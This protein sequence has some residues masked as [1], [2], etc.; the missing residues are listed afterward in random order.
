[1]L[2]IFCKYLLIYSLL[3]ITFNYFNPC[4]IKRKFKYASYYLTIF[5]QGIILPY[6]YLN[7][8]ANSKSIQIQETMFLSTISY[9]LV[10]LFINKNQI[11]KNIKFLAHHLLSIILLNFAI[12]NFDLS[13]Y[14][15]IGI[16]FYLEFG[17]L[18]ISI[19]DLFPS[20]I[21]YKLR[22]FFYLWS[23][24][25]I[26]KLLTILI[27]NNYLIL[28]FRLFLIHSFISFFLYFHN[29][30]IAYYLYKKILH[31]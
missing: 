9:F 4:K 3:G 23:R 13:K 10:D 18:W 22:F 29:C 8:D 7:I 24:I 6:Y 21:N 16:L 25:F 27:Y 30:I 14:Y 1:M 20:R 28:D 17:S 11:F 5:H 15:V 19:T 26:L 12:F 2:L 31:L